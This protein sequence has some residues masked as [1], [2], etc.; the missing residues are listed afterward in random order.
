MTDTTTRLMDMVNNGRLDKTTAAMLF[1]V[2]WT[3]SGKRE[4]IIK[5]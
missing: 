1:N 2:V 4:Y 3:V 5:D